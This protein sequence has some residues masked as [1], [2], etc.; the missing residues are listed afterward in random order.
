MADGHQLSNEEQICIMEMVKSGKMTQ[1][2]A[3]K[4]AAKKVC[5]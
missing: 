2:E 1:D 3:L 4:L 5:N